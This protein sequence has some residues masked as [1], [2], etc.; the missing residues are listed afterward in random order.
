[1]VIKNDHGDIFFVCDLFL[2]RR[3]KKITEAFSCKDTWDCL[4]KNDRTDKLFVNMTKNYHT[5]NCAF[6]VMK[7][8][9]TPTVTEKQ[10]W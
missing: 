6:T 10:I 2:S 9:D 8:V 1:M 3:Q 7:T 4:I 5:D